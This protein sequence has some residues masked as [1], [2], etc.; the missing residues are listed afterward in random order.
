MLFATGWVWVSTSA[1]V[2]SIFCMR[3]LRSC[4]VLLFCHCLFMLWQLRVPV[5]R[6][7]LGRTDLCFGMLFMGPCTKY[8]RNMHFPRPSRECSLCVLY[9]C[10][11]RYN[12]FCCL[13]WPC[14]GP[15]T[16]CGRCGRTCNVRYRE[17]SNSAYLLRRCVYDSLATFMALRLYGLV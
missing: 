1:H 16:L 6:D 8:Y 14:V 7:L 15:G 17:Q 13:F 4:I 3:P 10:C 5:W 11:W 9:S 2:C 12:S